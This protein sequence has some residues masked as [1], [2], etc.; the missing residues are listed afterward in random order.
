M[1]VSFRPRV[2]SPCKA[3]QATLWLR[4][5]SGEPKTGLV[6][7]SPQQVS[8]GMLNLERSAHSDQTNPQKTADL[9]KE[10]GR[11]PP[12]LRQQAVLQ[13]LVMNQEQE[14]KRLLCLLRG[15]SLEDLQE[16]DSDLLIKEGKIISPSLLEL[17]TSLTDSSFSHRSSRASCFQECL[18]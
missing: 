7:G 2:K 4:R 18:D 5:D 17:V 6:S 15:V 10:G 1:F 8:V 14:R 13:L 3:E 11:K 16:P 12:L 9:R